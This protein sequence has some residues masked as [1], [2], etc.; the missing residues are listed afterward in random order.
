[1]GRRDAAAMS[2]VYA[3]D[4]ISVV[5]GMLPLRGRRAIRDAME[6]TIEQ[7]VVGIESNSTELYAVGDKVCETGRAMFRKRSGER[8]AAMRFMTLW[9]QE[10]GHWRIYRDYVTPEEVGR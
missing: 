3:E 4:A 9:K 1:M 8:A 2:L 7:G 6:Q 10:G 5:P